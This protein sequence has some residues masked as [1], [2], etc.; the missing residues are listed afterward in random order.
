PISP[1]ISAAP[2]RSFS[3]RRIRASGGHSDAARECCGKRSLR[4]SPLMRY[5]SHFMERTPEPDDLMDE[6][7]QAAAYAA[8]DWSESHGRIP[9]YF[10]GRFPD[11]SA[12]V[13]LDLGC[14][15]ADVTVRF[16]QAFPGVTALG[17]DGS[18]AM[19]E[20][21]RSRVRDERL[22]SR[23]RLE[24]HYLPDPFLET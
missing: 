8:E 23:I 6:Q 3:D 17:V 12:G 11:F 14:G 1:L 24:N 16:V 20:F 13:V 21:G 5:Y 22:E 19:L 4:I 18:N 15:A 2:P 10:R 7:D 9:G